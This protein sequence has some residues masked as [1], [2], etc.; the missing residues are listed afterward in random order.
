MVFQPG[1]NSGSQGTNEA[2]MNQCVLWCSYDG[3][4]TQLHCEYIR[5]EKYVKEV[6]MAVTVG[7][8]YCQNS[9]H[10]QIV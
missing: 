10:T 5:K 1:R 9:L 3:P 2:T 7:A 6:M 4:I 8:Q